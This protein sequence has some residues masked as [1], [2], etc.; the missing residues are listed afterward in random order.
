MTQGPAN[1]VERGLWAA[2]EGRLAVEEWLVQLL[3]AQVWVPLS[4]PAAAGL[5]V[6]SIDESS[7]VPVFTSLEQLRVAVPEGSYVAPPVR[8]LVASLPESVG[9]AV[10]PG[11]EVG[12]PLSASVVRQAAGLSTTL[13]AGTKVRIGEPAVEPVELVAEVT[14]ELDTVPAVR[15][16]RRAWAAVGD[17]RPGLVVAVDVDPDNSST[18][19]AV[20]EAVRRAAGSSPTDFPVDVVFDNDRD[21]FVQWMHEHAEPFYQRR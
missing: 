6:M 5:P 20:L 12:L 7:Y 15:A 17:S 11:G 8:E 10:N 13:S 9:L 2:S 21:V 14:R 1:D 3:S 18:R 19:D 4:D 16:A